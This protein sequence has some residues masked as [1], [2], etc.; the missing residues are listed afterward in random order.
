MREAGD[1]GTPRTQR[2]EDAARLEAE[3]RAVEDGLRVEVLQAHQARQEARSALRTSA[4]GLA[5]A[6]EA[7]RVRRLLFDHGRATS[8]EVIDAETNLLGARLEQVNAQVNLLLA[9]ARLE[10]AV[11]RDVTST[12]E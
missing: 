12:P 1:S 7:Y 4:R 3:R 11:G 9:R 8:V 5:A 2:T 10:H 6:E